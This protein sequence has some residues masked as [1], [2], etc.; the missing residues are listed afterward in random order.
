M[1]ASSRLKDQREDCTAAGVVA[2]AD[3]AVMR[4]HDL[5]HDRKP[6]PGALPKTIPAPPKAIEDML[7]IS[8][9]NPGTA[10]GDLD[11]RRRTHLDDDL[12]ARRGVGYRVFDEISDRILDRMAIATDDDRLLRP[13]RGERAHARQGGRRH[14]RDNIACHGAE[15]DRTGDI[16]GDCIQTSHPEQLLDQLAFPRSIAELGIAREEF[17]RAIPELAKNAFD[18]PSWRSNPRMPLRSELV[19]LFWKAYEG[20]GISKTACVSQEQA[21]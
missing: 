9:R 19:E 4:P 11:G 21:V 16:Q 5:A 1:R 10:I 18:D 12:G 8:E 13:L 20:R 2:D 17:E 15:I 7:S 14:V 3:A 6:E